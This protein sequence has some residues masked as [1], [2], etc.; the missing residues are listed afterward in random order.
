MVVDFDPVAF[1]L[2]GLS[3]HWYGLMY[4]VGFVGAWWLGRLR[5][6]RP[7]SGWTAAQVDDL[8][9]YAG[10]GVILGGRLGYVL[11]YNLGPFFDDPLMLFRIK[12]GGMS[13]HGGLLGVM[14]G[15]WLFSRKYHKR[16]FVTLDFVAPLVPLGL[17]AGRIGNFINGEL[18]GKPTDLPWGMVFPLAGPEAR[19]PNPLYEALLEGLVLFVILWWFSSRSRPQRAVSGVFALG[20]GVFRFAVEF[21]R[22]PDAHIGYLAWGWLTMGQLLSLPLILAG[23]FLLGLAYRRPSRRQQEI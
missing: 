20:Y 22:T 8:L 17:G 2:F 7:D 5:A 11:F 4:L 18:W 16:Y 23:L 3:V 13:F 19:H 9:F 15:L 6:R 14:L 12:E 21:V 1:E 10:L